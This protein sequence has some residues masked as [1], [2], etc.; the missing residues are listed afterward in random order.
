MHAYRIEEE[1]ISMQTIRTVSSHKIV[2]NIGLLWPKNGIASCWI[3]IGIAEAEGLVLL[4]VVLLF[5]M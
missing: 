4:A 1:Q 3:H 5:C 2:L